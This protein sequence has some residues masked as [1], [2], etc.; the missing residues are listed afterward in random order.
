MGS[1]MPVA[2][3]TSSAREMAEETLRWDRMARTVLPARAAP[4]ATRASLAQRVGKLAFTSCEGRGES[5]A[6]PPP[7]L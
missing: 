2:R 5:Q 7:T 6:L 1:T 4:S 3:F